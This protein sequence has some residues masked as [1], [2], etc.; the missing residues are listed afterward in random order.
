MGEAKSKEHQVVFGLSADR[1]FVILGISE[2][3]WNF[4]KDGKTHNF[5]LEQLGFPVSI[6]MYGAATRAQAYDM[7]SHLTD[8]KKDPQLV[9]L[10]SDFSIPE[11]QKALPRMRAAARNYLLDYVGPERPDEWFDGLFDAIFKGTHKS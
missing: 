10:E 6:V 5:N 7:I 4:M 11:D 9:D 2:A 8:N 1:R 3:S